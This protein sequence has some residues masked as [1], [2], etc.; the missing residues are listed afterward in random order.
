MGVPVQDLGCYGDIV[1]LFDAT[2]V[3][4]SFALDLFG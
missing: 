2:L 3:P 1:L 4:M